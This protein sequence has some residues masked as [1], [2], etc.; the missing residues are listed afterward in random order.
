MKTKVYFSLI[1]CVLL[2]N[3]S[4]KRCIKCVCEHEFGKIEKESCYSGPGTKHLIENAKNDFYN[5]NNC[6]YV[7][8]K[9]I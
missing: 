9:D 7:S 4:C 3:T 1:L 5:K 2:M 8:C 6:E